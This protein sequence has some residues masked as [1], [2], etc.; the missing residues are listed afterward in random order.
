M[1]FLG[2]DL[3]T[4]ALKAVLVDEAQSILAEAT[5]PLGISTPRPGW[6]EQ[7]P[8]DW[9]MALQTALARLREMHPLALRAV[10]AL[11]LSGQMH[12]AVLLDGEGRPIRRAILWNDGRATAECDALQDVV[13]DLERIAGIIAMPGFTA[14]KL[15][16]LKLHEPQGF[17]RIANVVSPKDFL[18]LRMTGE[19]ATDMSDAAGTLWLDEAARDWSDAILA[20]CG[21]DRSTMPRLGEGSAPGGE[22]RPHAA[23]ALGIDGPVVVAGGAGD[24]AAAAIGIGAVE[25]GDAF[26]S[27]GTSAQFFVTD[28]RYRPQPG[29]LLHAFAHALP[30]RWFR[31]A[32]ML[33][34]ASCLDFVARLIGE[35]DIAALLQRTE[36]AYRG[37]SRLIFLPY[38][39]GERTP[40]NDPFARGVFAGL[41]HD[42]GPTD[43]AQAVLEGVAFSLLEAR[44]L[45]EKAGVALAGIAAVGGGARSRF[46]M[47]LVSHVIGLPVVRYRGS[48]T[49]PAFGAARLA[50]MALTGEPPSAVC[51]KPEVLDALR[52]NPALTEA[53]AERFEKYRTLYRNLTPEFRRIRGIAVPS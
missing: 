22:I 12:G 47:Q 16:W 43:L 4:S 33:N 17:A 26:V 53:Y 15:L 31:M 20:A 30:N 8:E 37:P 49:G 2:I 14:P 44:Q 7:S 3:G 27:L 51:V 45:M 39:S 5:I 50:R 48:E 46:W 25:D 35:N 11:G 34:G 40:H 28:G 38:L 6:F 10:R 13:P 1:T 42:C 52:P 23:A 9:W 24:A 19:V 32:A 41:D 29:T 21:L 18:R 36:A